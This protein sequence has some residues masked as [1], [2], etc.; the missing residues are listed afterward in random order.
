MGNIKA[1]QKQAAALADSLVKSLKVKA[2]WSEAFD[3]GQTCT[4]KTVASMKPYPSRDYEVKRAYLVRSDNV[5][6][7]I[8]LQQ[9]ETLTTGSDFDLSQWFKKIVTE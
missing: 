2:I 8:T 3:K 5:E 1:K 6:R 9:Y 4:L 7:E